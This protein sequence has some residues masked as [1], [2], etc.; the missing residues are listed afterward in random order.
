MK[1]WITALLVW[2]TCMAGA[3]DY[4]VGPASAG[5]ADGSSKANRLAWDQTM[6]SGKKG[7]NEGG[8]NRLIMVDGNYAPGMTVSSGGYITFIAENKWMAIITNAPSW[9]IAANDAP[10][11]TG[12]GVIFDGLRI[13]N[14]VNNGIELG[15]GCTVRNCLIQWS[16]WGSG[17]TTG[18]GIQGA[19]YSSNNVMEYNLIEYSGTT[20]DDGVKGHG[21][22]I[23]S[24]SIGNVI[25]GNVIRHTQGYGIQYDSSYTGDWNHLGQMYN[26]IIYDTTNHFGITSYC[27]LDGGPGPAGTNYIY[28]NIIFDGLQCKYGYHYVS[29]NIIFKGVNWTPMTNAGSATIIAGHNF[30]TNNFSGFS[31]SDT[32]NVAPGFVDS[33]KAL[34]WLLSAAPALT[35]SVATAVTQDFFG[36]TIASP[37]WMGPAGYSNA[38]AADT[39]DL[40]VDGSNFWLGLTN[41]VA[42]S[43]PT[44]KV[45]TTRLIIGP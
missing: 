12:I 35:N 4:W 8:R 29:N 36:L 19:R 24:G 7:A 20:Y 10:G 13:T 41:A 44:N 28:N 39:R 37:T 34:F 9:G 16:G 15:V 3:T 40:T 30:S 42:A 45:Y 11:S 38:Y 17:A 32:T 2:T 14:S 26:N 18:S 27:G 43:P 6:I 1:T 23:Y 22:G 31:A 5:S 25:R 21:H 33:S